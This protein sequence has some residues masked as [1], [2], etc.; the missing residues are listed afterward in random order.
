MLDLM[1]VLKTNKI[2]LNAYENY[3]ISSKKKLGDC[4]KTHWSDKK[5]KS[6]DYWKNL[7]GVQD[8][9]IISFNVN[10]YSLGFIFEENEQKYFAYITRDNNRCT[11]LENL[12]VC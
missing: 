9:K 8:L 4:Y 5:Q 11:L 3:K 6:F 7:E 2:M 12:K 10:F 1:N